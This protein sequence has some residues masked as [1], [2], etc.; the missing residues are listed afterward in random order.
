M[1]NEIQKLVRENPGQLSREEYLEVAKKVVVLMNKP[2]NLLIFE[3]IIIP[4]ESLILK[5]LI[6]IFYDYMRCIRG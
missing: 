3:L 4:V 6:Y 1:I 2:C 5:I